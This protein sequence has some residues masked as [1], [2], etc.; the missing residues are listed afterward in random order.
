MYLAVFLALIVGA[1][2]GMLI[3]AIIFAG[4]DHK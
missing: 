1:V 3:S 2:A 4:G